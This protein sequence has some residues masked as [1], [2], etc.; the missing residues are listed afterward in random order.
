MNLLKITIVIII[1]I[2]II[3]QEHKTAVTVTRCILPEEA[4]EHMPENSDFDCHCP[5]QKVFIWL[6][7][8]S[9]VRI[10]TFYAV[11]SAAG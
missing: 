9:W 6:E 2:I 3:I 5:L 10:V 1:I 4:T 7:G 11:L 8:L